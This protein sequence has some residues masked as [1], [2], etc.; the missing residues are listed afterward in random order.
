[1]S[2]TDV[3]DMLMDGID[4]RL[5]YDLFPSQTGIYVETAMSNCCTTGCNP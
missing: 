5:N 4:I 3:N 1:M 2:Y